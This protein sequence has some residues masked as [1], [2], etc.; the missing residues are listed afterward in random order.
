[1]LSLTTDDLVGGGMAPT[2]VSCG[3]PFV[4]V[5]VR[6]SDAVARARA[7]AER[8][9][10]TL[11]GCVSDKVFVFAL[12]S[13]AGADVHARMFSPAIGIPEDPATGSA[14]VALGG[15]LAAREPRR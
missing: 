11:A 9:A 5:P 14:A 6:S 8:F 10:A 2:V 12:S 3:M 7:N 15:Y 1:M 4:M 13:A